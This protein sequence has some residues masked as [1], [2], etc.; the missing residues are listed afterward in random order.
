[1]GDGDTGQMLDTR[2][3]SCRLLAKVKS[4]K[5]QLVSLS[6]VGRRFHAVGIGDDRSGVFLALRH[7][8]S[9]Y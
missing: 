2:K 8:G 6:L 1:M 9:P 5:A 3:Q 4:E 7:F